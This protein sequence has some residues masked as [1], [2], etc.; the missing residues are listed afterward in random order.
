MPLPGQLKLYLGEMSFEYPFGHNLIKTR[1]SY[2][3]SPRSM[4]MADY[5]D[6]YG[7]APPKSRMSSFPK[8]KSKKSKGGLLPFA[9]ARCSVP[10]NAGSDEEEDTS[11]AGSWS[12]DEEDAI[13]TTN[14][15]SNLSS[16]AALKL[17]LTQNPNGSFPVSEDVTK[18]MNLDLA[19]VLD[20]EKS[21]DPQAWMTLVC[22]AFLKTFCEGEK[23][24]WELVVTK[25]EK[26]LTSSFPN[27]GE[28][29]MQRAVE[30]LKNK[31]ITN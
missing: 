27:V 7:S 23:I 25:A 18:V 9:A 28:N 12:D 8:S 15:L 13:K 11:D 31:I 16:S 20:H 21:M 29:E 19:E 2:C 1:K 4:A 22:T 30:F 24:I 26:W 5:D 10:Q 3:I 6:L 17:T 14:S